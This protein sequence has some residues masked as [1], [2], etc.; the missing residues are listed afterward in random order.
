MTLLSSFSPSIFILNVTVFAIV[1]FICYVRP[2]MDELLHSVAEVVRLAGVWDVL[3]FL[4]VATMVV[5][6]LI[7]ICRKANE[8]EKPSE[9]TTTFVFKIED[10]SK[11]E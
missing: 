3:L 6:S 4:I 5:G 11:S 1:R 8:K 2:I 9:D 10:R 7:G